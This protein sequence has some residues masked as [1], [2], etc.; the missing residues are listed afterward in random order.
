MYSVDDG[1]CFALAA[2]AA[3]DSQ[4]D[5]SQDSTADAVETMLHLSLADAPLPSGLPSAD[6]SVTGTRQDWLTLLRMPSVRRVVGE[7]GFMDS[8]DVD[9]PQGTVHAADLATI[10]GTSRSLNGSKVV[11]SHVLQAIADAEEAAAAAALAPRVTVNGIEYVMPEQFGVVEPGVYR[12]AYPTPAMLPF[13]DALHLRTVI[14]LLD[15]LPREYEEHLART[16]V[17]YV[18]CAVKGNKAHCEEMD[19]GIVRGALLKLI[20]SRNFPVLVHCR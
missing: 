13:L 7:A 18:H 19:R 12:S 4:T 6:A 1:T 8:V 16:G 2:I 3:R 15:R 10:L 20:D 14:N 5:V 11:P 17:T 9:S